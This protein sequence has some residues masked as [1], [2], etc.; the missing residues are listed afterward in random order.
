MPRAKANSVDRHVAA[1]LRAT[2]LL[3]QTEAGEAV[4]VR[5][6]QI[7]KYESGRNRVTAGA[8]SKLAVLYGKLIDSFFP[9]VK[10]G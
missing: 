3:T 7:Q 4:G 5:F 8:L 9:T 10:R 6:R 2:R 1:K